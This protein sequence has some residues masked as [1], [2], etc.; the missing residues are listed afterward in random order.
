MLSSSNRLKRLWLIP[1]LG[2]AGAC[3]EPQ[4]PGP[5][6]VV[7][8]SAG[9]RV[10]TWE[11]GGVDA[12]SYRHLGE[13]DLR[14]GV[15]EGDPE[16][17]F[18]RIVDLLVLPDDGLVVSDANAPGMRIFDRNGGFVRTLGGRGEGPGEFAGAP[19][20]AGL[21]GDTLHA[22]DARTGRR[23]AFT[24]RGELV[25]SVAMT[26]GGGYRLQALDHVGDGVFLATSKWL[27][28]DTRDEFHDFRLEVDSIVVER[29]SATG[30]ILDTMTVMAD[31]TLMR[32]VRD[33]GPGVFRTLQAEPPHRA[34]A[35]LEVA[36]GHVVLG[37]S[38]V[39]SLDLY[40]RSGSPTRVRVVGAGNPAGAGA[41]R[42]HMEA[43][44]RED[45]GDDPIDE[46]TQTLYLDMLPDRLP[47]FHRAVVT[48]DGDV[49]VARSE[50][51]GERGYEW[52]V[53]SQEGELRGLVRTPPGMR[54]LAV[55]PTWVIGV[56]TDDF[57]VPFLHRY[58]LEEPRGDAP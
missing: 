6:S 3:A 42:S 27:D 32:T 53:F 46:M 25:E 14:I 9:V 54:L 26:S 52:L 58:P 38:D 24:V 40:P 48:S 29:V 41:I 35:V 56:V 7:T 37:R 1:V 11:L 8:D 20:L 30:D 49:W 50:L 22:W 28:P 19:L 47:A 15:V 31:Q 17:A 33:G 5:T 51:D 36:A 16:Y 45:F 34:R 39:F 44:L 23:T 13:P 12:P 18:S 4:A 10:V 21:T 55:Q 43:L 57:D 2:M